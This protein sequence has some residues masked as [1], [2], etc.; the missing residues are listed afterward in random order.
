VLLAVRSQKCDFQHQ[1]PA[2]TREMP[3]MQNRSPRRILGQPA[4]HIVI[5]LGFAVAFL[6]PIFVFTEPRHTFHFLY[7]AWFSSILASF[8]I[9][10]GLPPEPA[11][12]AAGGDPAPPGRNAPG[13]A[14]TR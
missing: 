2:A 1:V 7:A 4:L 5:A 10:R 13:A 6:W 12:D 8:A 14:E 9:S 3:V 11:S